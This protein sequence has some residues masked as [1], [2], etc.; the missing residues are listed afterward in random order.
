[1]YVLALEDSCPYWM[2]RGFVLEEGAN[3]RARL[4][5]FPDTHLLRRAGDPIDAGDAADLE[6]AVEHEAEEEAGEA[7]ADGGDDAGD[8]GDAE[9]ADEDDAL[10][11]AL[12]LSLPQPAPAAEAAAPDGGG[13]GPAE[14]DDDDLEAAIALS[15]GPQP[16]SS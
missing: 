5:I 12:M 14:D 1:M 4:N 11:R 3:L 10:Q 9:E 2:N 15:L 13:A 7:D 8:G 16:S 6:L